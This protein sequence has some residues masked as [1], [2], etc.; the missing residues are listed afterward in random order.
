MT[1]HYLPLRVEKEMVDFHQVVKQ[2]LTEFPIAK[3][4]VLIATLFGE[5]VFD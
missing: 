2:E 3:L 1:T 4:N 5:N